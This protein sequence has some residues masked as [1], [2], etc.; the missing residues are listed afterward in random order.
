MFRNVVRQAVKRAG[1]RAVR[2]R[3]SRFAPRAF[4]TTTPLASSSSNV[5][6]E[7]KRVH[8]GTNH[9]SMNVARG[10]TVTE[11]PFQKLLAANRGEIATRISRGASELGIQTVGIYSHEGTCVDHQ[12]VVVLHQGRQTHNGH[13]QRKRASKDPSKKDRFAGLSRKTPFIFTW[14]NTHSCRSSTTV[15]FA[16]QRVFFMSHCR[17]SPF[18]SRKQ[19]VKLVFELHLTQFG[20]VCFLVLYNWP[21]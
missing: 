8:V 13:G 1:R 21:G 2:P 5:A 9:P 4:S 11:P 6:A 20:L 7:Q 19:R 3:T 18:Q 12:R 15:F 10:V 16:T 17:R 14:V